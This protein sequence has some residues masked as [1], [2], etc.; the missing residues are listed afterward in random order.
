MTQQE[1]KQRWL[2][3]SV[4]MILRE[5]IVI[6]GTTFLVLL[7]FRWMGMY[8][9]EQVLRVVLILAWKFFGLTGFVAGVVVILRFQYR[10]KLLQIEAEMRK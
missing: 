7:M 2:Q 4:T 3:L 10:V 1:Y 8:P 6:Y 9:H 5:L